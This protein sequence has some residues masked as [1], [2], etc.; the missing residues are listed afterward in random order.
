[1]DFINI[2]PKDAFSFYFNFFASDWSISSIVIFKKLAISA[3]DDFF[4]FQ[5]KA[6]S[7]CVPPGVLP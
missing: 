3:S 7:A 4:K 1:M 5:P 6:Y 2:Y